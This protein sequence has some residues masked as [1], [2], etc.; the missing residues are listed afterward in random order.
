MIYNSLL[1]LHISNDIKRFIMD[2]TCRHKQLN[3][4]FQTS[5]EEV[6]AMMFVNCIC[7]SHGES[8]IADFRVVTTHPSGQKTSTGWSIYV[9]TSLSPRDVPRRPNLDI[10]FKGRPGDV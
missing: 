6:N 4:I 3:V 1:M 8:L 10:K 9:Q 2:N 7:D 5:S